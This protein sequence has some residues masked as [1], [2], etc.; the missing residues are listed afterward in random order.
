MELFSNEITMK[1]GPKI[2]EM[3]FGISKKGNVANSN[4]YCNRRTKN[5][6]KIFSEWNFADRKKTEMF[7][8]GTYMLIGKQRTVEKKFQSGISLIEKWKFYKLQFSV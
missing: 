7:E 3:E 1:I 6:G 5:N 4:C 2:I 8:I